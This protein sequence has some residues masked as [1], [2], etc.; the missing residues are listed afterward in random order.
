MAFLESSS[1]VLAIAIT[2]CLLYIL[3][4]ALYRASIHPLAE[5]PGPRLAALTSWYEFYH[6]CFKRGRFTWDIQRLHERYGQSWSKKPPCITK[7]PVLVTCLHP[8]DVTGPIV[9]I[10]PH[11]LH[12]N[13]PYFSD[14]LFS[15][16]ERFDRHKGVVQHFG[17]DF[18]TV[19]T[20]PYDSHKIRRG[21][22][23]PFFGR[24]MVSTLSNEDIIRRKVERLCCRIEEYCELKQ[25]MNLGLALKCLVTDVIS[26]YA[27]GT[28]YDLMDTPDFGVAR[29]EAQRRTGE[30][31]VLGKHFPWLIPVLRRLPSWLITML[32][33]GM[34]KLLG[35][36][37]VSCWCF[38]RIYCLLTLDAGY[39]STSN[40][41]SEGTK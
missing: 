19:F 9:R 31:A 37:K 39:R 3:T 24:N 14:D 15:F 41:Y 1:G 4:G 26:E 2:L 12:I 5:F 27:L 36:M 30:F 11:E 34:G 32:S 28:S 25:P 18:A 6:N 13:D 20:V 29:F 17:M 23:A 33:P 40:G 38:T 8:F 35:R 21:A 7:I 22:L 10:T 16:K